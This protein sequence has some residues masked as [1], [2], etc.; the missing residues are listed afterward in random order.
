M[1]PPL[2]AYNARGVELLCDIVRAQAA[3]QPCP[4]CKQ[5]LEEVQI[6]V[7]TI[8]DD[9]VILDLICNSCR[10]GFQATVGPASGDGVAVIQ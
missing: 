1:G 4:A 9:Q 5:P 6:E 2:E 7:R 8:S 10:N 3:T